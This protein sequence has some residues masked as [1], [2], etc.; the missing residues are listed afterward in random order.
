MTDWLRANPL[1]TLLGVAGLLL[2]IVI[3]LEAA[4]GSSL[5][6]VMQAGGGRRAVPAE[7]QLLPPLAA[8]GPEV[9]YPETVERPLWVPT[10]RPAPEA[11]A[12]AN[13]QKG[14]YVLQGV[15]VVG[16]NRIAMLREKSSGKV[17]RVEAGKDFNGMKVVAIE[18]ESVTLGLGND[19]EKLVLNVLK[20]MGPLPPAVPAGPF[21]TAPAIP[22]APPPAPGTPLGPGQPAGAAPGFGTIGN[23]A[24][25]V[26][27]AARPVPQAAAAAPA[28]LSPEEAL[29]RRRAARRQQQGN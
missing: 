19:E 11:P 13:V 4:F 26:N 1:L 23:P 21:A 16:D 28:P 29:A 2:A 24:G 8:V 15:I 7:A 9:A 3:A 14:Q 10:R 27:P 17:H 5:G 12:A 6:K 18:K 20:P 22:A 25:A